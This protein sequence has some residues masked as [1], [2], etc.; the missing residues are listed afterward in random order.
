MLSPKHP[1]MRSSCSH[2]FSVRKV[3]GIHRFRK[4]RRVCLRRFQASA[5]PTPFNAIRTKFDSHNVLTLDT[6]IFPAQHTMVGCLSSSTI[7]NLRTPWAGIPTH[8]PPTPFPGLLYTGPQPRAR[9]I[10]RHDR[11]LLQ[12]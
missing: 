6:P 9:R 8:S 4:M 5:T 11:H 1:I 3:H 12:R 10:L 2:L 7:Y